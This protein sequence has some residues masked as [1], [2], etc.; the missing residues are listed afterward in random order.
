MAESKK[1]KTIKNKDMSPSN[2]ERGDRLSIVTNYIK[3]EH[4]IHQNDIVEKFNEDP[5]YA[6][7]P[8]GGYSHYKSGDTRIPD[9]LITFLFENY[10]I[11][12]DYINCKSNFMINIEN[13]KLKHF[14]Q[15]VTDWM[16]SYEKSKCAIAPERVLHIEMDGGFYSFLITNSLIQLLEKELKETKNTL[17]DESK[18]TTNN[19]EENVERFV[20]IPESKWV[21]LIE[22]LKLYVP[23]NTQENFEELNKYTF[24][25]IE[26]N[27]V[28]S[29]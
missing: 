23:N 16:T 25:K 7:I 29:I 24:S 21:E 28:N 15:I 17:V 4:N 20:L 12:P 6:S 14:E 2:A 26:D 8:D 5:R 18:K 19:E 3:N 13:D 10:N 22:M 11:N 9:D 1:T 27:D